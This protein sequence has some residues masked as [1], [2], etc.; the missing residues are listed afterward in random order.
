MDIAIMQIAL[1]VLR[2][3]SEHTDP[4]SEDVAAL[5]TR[6]GP[7]ADELPVDDL[8]RSVIDLCLREAKGRNTARA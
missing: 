6:L 5:R 8:A 2:A 1:G 7:D 3:C 4:R